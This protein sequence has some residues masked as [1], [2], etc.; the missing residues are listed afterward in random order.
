MTEPSKMTVAVLRKELEKK[1]L[2]TTGLKAALVE[3]LTKALESG[4][5]DEP[6]AAATEAEV[7]IPS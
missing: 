3:R 1:G 7:R 5:G 2:D 4:V 6:A